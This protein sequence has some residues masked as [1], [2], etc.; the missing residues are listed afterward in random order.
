[1]TTSNSIYKDFVKAQKEFKPVVF[2]KVNPFHK[3]KYADLGSHLD[4]V[5]G[6][7]NNNNFSLI[8][9]THECNIGVSVETILI[10]ESGEQISGG[11]LNIPVVK[12][13]PQGHGAA[14]TYARRFSLGAL[15]S[16]HGEEDNDGNEHFSEK[17][18]VK[19]VNKPIIENKV[20][21]LKK[22]QLE[23]HKHALI[24]NAEKKASNGL[25]ALEEFWKVNLSDYER[26]ILKDKLEGFK[27]KAKEADEIN[28]TVEK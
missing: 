11:I 25:K 22:L 9:K 5:I 27:I 4:S 21:D 3:S 12:N 13:E 18:Q 20:D 16:L 2:N 6:A 10:H 17:Q 1:M 14:L 28:K 15:L 26:D 23:K 8:Q 19:F 7:L 24:L